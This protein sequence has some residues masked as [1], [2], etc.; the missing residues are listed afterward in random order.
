MFKRGFIREAPK[1]VV[2]DTNPVFFLQVCVCRDVP[3]ADEHKN[4]AL[5]ITD[6]PHKDY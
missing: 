6:P 2:P 1:V 5:T 3:P 4:T